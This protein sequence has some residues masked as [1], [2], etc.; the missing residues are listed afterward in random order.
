M[1]DITAKSP[2]CRTAIAEV[3]VELGAEIIG[4]FSNNELQGP[5]GPVFQTA[6]ISGTM[7]VENSQPMSCPLK[8]NFFQSFLFV[9]MI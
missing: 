8:R 6:I 3:C 4:K 1:V 2:N 9:W 7:A 5:K